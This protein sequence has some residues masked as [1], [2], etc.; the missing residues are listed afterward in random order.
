MKR[1][2][3]A[4]PYVVWMIILILAPMLLIVYYA[5]TENV[6][7][8][9]VY[10]LSN[11][12]KAF[13]PMFMEVLLRSLW[14]A[15]IATLI[16]LA[17]GYPVSLMLARSKSKNVASLL[18]LFILPMWMNFLLRT[19][20]WLVLLDN[21]G[22]VNSFLTLLGLGKAQLLYTQSAV[23]LGMVYNFLPFMILPIHSVLVKISQN[24]IEAAEDLGANSLTVFRKVIFPLSIPG[25]VTGIIMVFVPAITTFAISRLLGG[26]QFMLFG[27]LI[28][29]QFILVQDWHFGSALS[30]IMLVLV[31]I[32]L[33]I[34]NKFDKDEGGRLW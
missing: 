33:A 4:L 6:D 30:L 1:S 28:E 26:S 18:V 13:D 27:D 12:L 2:Y 11:M 8:G 29:N 34:T 21:N 5:F 20:A 17:L 32:S 7:G 22:L 31:L 15:L 25:V 3:F 16:C 10:S 9:V 24:Q 19:Y 23:V 14:L